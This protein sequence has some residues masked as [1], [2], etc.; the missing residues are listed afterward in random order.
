[1]GGGSAHAVMHLS[2]SFS[3]LV[4]TACFYGSTVVLAQESSNHDVVPTRRQTRLLT[5]P[6]FA[7]RPCPCRVGAYRPL[8]QHHTGTTTP[9][10]AGTTCESSTS[11]QPGRGSRQPNGATTSW[12]RTSI[13][14]SSTRN[15]TDTFVAT[16]PWFTATQIAVPR[17]S[18]Q[19]ELSTISTAQRPCWIGEALRLTSGMPAEMR[20]G[21]RNSRPY[22]S[23][24]LSSGKEQ[25]HAKIQTLSRSSREALV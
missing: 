2:Q 9:P 3:V 22:H 14:A 1:M 18:A 10:S 21:G 13:F 16:L 25:T 15:R 17:S 5:H 7:W 8:R 4:N 19:A 20:R 6:V 24:S 11:R 23:P 12:W